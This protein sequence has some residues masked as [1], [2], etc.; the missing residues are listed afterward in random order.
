MKIIDR[1]Y[2]GKT[3]PYC[4]FPIKQDSEA[5][6]CRACQVPHHRECWEENGGCTTFG[7][8][9]TSFS[10][11][12]GRIEIS[13][14][15]GPEN[16]R[17]TSLNGGINKFLAAALVMA[18]LVI[19]LLS[20]NL[21]QGDDSEAIDPSESAETADSEGET[22][23]VQR[24]EENYDSEIIDVIN[25]ADYMIDYEHGKIPL[26]EVEIGAK[27][28]D[29]TWEWEFRTG[30]DYTLQTGD[31]TK[32]VTWIVVAKDHY[33]GIEPSVTLLSK[34][35]VGKHVYDNST[36]KTDYGD[37]GFN[38][39]G[40]SGTHESANRGLRPWLNSRG[41]HKDEGF[42]HAFSADFKSA[43]IETPVPNREWEKGNSYITKDRVFIPSITELGVASHSHSKTAG[44]SE[45]LNEI[46]DVYYHIDYTTY[47]I[48]A[49]YPYFSITGN[50]KG[51]GMLNK[52]SY[53]YWT[54]SPDSGNEYAL[55]SV[56]PDGYFYGGLDLPHYGGYTPFKPYYSYIGVR[57]VLNLQSD[58]LVSEIP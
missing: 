2:I 8:Q 45:N 7:C 24:I 48:G 1:P 46:V 39:W 11:P 55:H 17:A 54:R 47:E 19:G 22:D 49:A 29:P 18:L 34:K 14:S 13:E 15:S 10:T 6:Q 28:V 50:E 57:P 16:E 27:V 44:V 12:A 51:I 33:N 26:S 30:D 42:H 3:C 23:L 9:E 31:E 35:L 21:L 37:Y 52:K 41:I 38:H 53:W 58:T 25:E 5:V 32:P 20:Y 40:K 36:H 43:V 56:G 4:Q